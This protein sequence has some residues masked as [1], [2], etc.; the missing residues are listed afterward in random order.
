MG[1]QDIWVSSLTVFDLLGVPRQKVSGSGLPVC[2]AGLL[3]TLLSAE[4][5]CKFKVL[6]CT[7][8]P[9]LKRRSLQFL[10]QFPLI[11]PADRVLLCRSFPKELVLF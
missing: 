9:L 1:A 5:S 3:F 4:M 8:G 2:Q 6:S 10:K 11:L 7:A